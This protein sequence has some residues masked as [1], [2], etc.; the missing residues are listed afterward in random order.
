MDVGI[1]I[2]KGAGVK[3]V[4]PELSRYSESTS[5][6]DDGR[7]LLT[8]KEEF[9]AILSLP[10]VEIERLPDDVV[11]GYPVKAFK[12]VDTSNRENTMYVS[13][14][15]ALE[16]LV[17]KCSITWKGRVDENVLFTLRDVK[18][19]PDLSVFDIPVTYTKI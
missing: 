10:G 5:V 16:N 6:S 4:F 1:L 9:E 15:P 13:V 3:A 14:A 18:L 2:E 12:V 19:D 7:P 8:I 17:V 11:S